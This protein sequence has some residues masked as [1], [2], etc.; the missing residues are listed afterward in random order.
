M[1]LIDADALIEE[2]K[3]AVEPKDMP[4]LLLKLFCGVIENRPTVDAV[5]VVRCGECIHAENPDKFYCECD[6]Y[7]VSNH[8][9]WYCGDGVRR[10]AETNE[11]D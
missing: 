10:G 7:Y 2:M 9:E 5:P 4:N 8:R 3:Q 1:R 11:A 6:M